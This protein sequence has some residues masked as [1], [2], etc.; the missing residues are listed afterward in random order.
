[1]NKFAIKDYIDKLIFGSY[2]IVTDV[3]LSVN[4]SVKKYTTACFFL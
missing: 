1:M 4:F 3:L 2:N